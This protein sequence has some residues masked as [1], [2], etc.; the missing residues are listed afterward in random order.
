MSLNPLAAEFVPPSV[1]RIPI[2]PAIPP[3]VL[4]QRVCSTCGG[5]YPKTRYSATQWK[6]D[7][8]ARRCKECTAKAIRDQ[9]KATAKAKEVRLRRLE[10]STKKKMSS[11]KDCGKKIDEKESRKKVISDDTAQLCCCANCGKE[12]SETIKLKNCTACYSVKYCSVACQKSHRQTHKDDCKRAIVPVERTP[13]HRARTEGGGISP[14]ERLTTYCELR[15]I[16]GLQG[17]NFGE[18]LSERLVV[19]GGSPNSRGCGMPGFS[20][21][22]YVYWG[23]PKGGCRADQKETSLRIEQQ[24]AALLEMDEK[25]L[26]E[27]SDE[28]EVYFEEVATLGNNICRKG[29]VAVDELKFEFTIDRLK[30]SIAIKNDAFELYELE[31]HGVLGTNGDS[32]DWSEYAEHYLEGEHA[33]PL[34]VS[35]P[36][37][38]GCTYVW[39]TGFWCR[40]PDLADTAAYRDRESNSLSPVTR[41]RQ[42][43]E[44]ASMMDFTIWSVEPE[45]KI[46]SRPARITTNRYWGISP[47]GGEDAEDHEK[48]FDHGAWDY[49]M[50]LDRIWVHDKF[51]L[52]EP[53][54]EEVA[55]LGN[56][57]TIAMIRHVYSHDRFGRVF[58]LVQFAAHKGWLEKHH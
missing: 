58:D 45:R 1:S 52:V 56:R 43:C 10:A 13:A 16:G 37:G 49:F 17:M 50:N 35:I 26:V 4:V 34:S 5:S 20:P 38:A 29:F 25:W 40:P 9:R 6:K 28:V 30:R 19:F 23:L 42:Y 8:G 57:N 31:R 53:V 51:P 15:T 3:A 18:L 33:L 24:I 12:G 46:M 32:V 11:A 2:P 54:M 47:T 39:S 27:N 7:D 22:R 48:E 21:K 36:D 55:E 14:K 44:L 41:L